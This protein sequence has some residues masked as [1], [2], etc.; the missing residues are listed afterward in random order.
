MPPALQHLSVVGWVEPG[1]LGVNGVLAVLY[2]GVTSG[3]L[4]RIFPDWTPVPARQ[5]AAFFA[6]LAVLYVGF[7]GPLDVLGDG[8]LYSA[9]MAQHL[10]EAFVAASLLLLGTPPWLVR[11]V[12][13]CTP[14]RLVFDRLTRP[15]IALSIFTAVMALVVMPPVYTVLEQNGTVHF[16]YHAGVLLAALAYWWAIL[17][18]LPERPPAHPGLAMLY[19][20]VVSLPM[21]GLF[22]PV[23]LDTRPYYSYYAATPRL[24]GLTQVGD[25]QLG[26]GL[27]LAGMHVP[28]GMAFVRSFRRWVREEG[29]GRVDPL[30]D[31]VDGRRTVSRARNPRVAPRCDEGG[32][33]TP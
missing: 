29:A 9:H 13:R 18:P 28:T 23:L 5:R 10:L 32:V 17:S 6:G 15:L 11:P 26:A 21:I 30:P 2:W 31:I 22:V 20:T 7:G 27:M 4:T 19:C 8:Y 16:L 33:P 24:F 3:P 14:T 25:Q 12:I 1:A